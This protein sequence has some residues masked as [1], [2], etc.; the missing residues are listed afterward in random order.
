MNRSAAL[1]AVALVLVSVGL[2]LSAGAVSGQSGAG[3]A[4][5]VGLEE[6]SPGGDHPTNA[7]PS[8]RAAGSYHEYAL[9]YLPTG[10]FVQEGEDS[11]S[12]R[13]MRPG[14]NVRRDKLQLWSKR[15][16]DADQKE[17]VIRIAY[18][19][20]GTRT[21]PNGTTRSVATN[22]T[23]T[24]KTATL[25]PGYDYVNLDVRSH[26][27]KK[28]TTMCVQ[29]ADDDENCLMNPTGLRWQFHH[30]TSKA[31]EAI[32]VNSR[33]GQL[34]WGYGLLVLPFFGFTAITL[35]T[36]REAVKRA[37]APPKISP[38]WWIVAAV[39]MA[40]TVV[41]GWTWISE[42]LVR[43]PWV[44][45]AAL[46]VLLGIMAVEWFSNR[47]FKSLFVRFSLTDGH[48]PP[49]EDMNEGENG[50]E[51]APGVLSAD[52]V[53]MHMVRSEDGKRSAIR[54]GLRKFVAR[55]RGATADFEPE[56]DMQTRVE[57]DVG[58]YE[59]LYLLHPED[60]EPLEYR[61]EHHELQVPELLEYEETEDGES[62]LVSV[63]AGTY[64]FGAG[65]LVVSYLAGGYLV[66]SEVLGLLVGA[67]VL[68]AWKLYRPVQGSLEANLAPIH[69][70][71]AVGTMLTHA[72]KL[73]QAKAWEELYR[74][75]TREKAQN[76]ADKKDLADQ[77][78]E[79][80][81]DQLFDRHTGESGGPVG[82]LSNGEAANGEEKAN[83]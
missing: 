20:E 5:K 25:G 57:C 60:E 28:R 62:E 3:A 81:L 38:I 26:Y 23:T 59:E 54:S 29:E 43:A 77:R 82:Q 74:D 24:T 11:P 1:V 47:T 36:G 33:G 75:L 31:Y 48:E 66:G 56:G 14:A 2:G 7:P 41:A 17:I 49:A 8:V 69:Y 13:Y 32:S 50:P 27:D 34:G 83:E 35:Y 30:H 73:G 68:T 40:I 16:Y 19:N 53:P 12:W 76:K 46:G 6:L 39:V 45:T 72:E 4:D 63:N 58:P 18:W 51:D 80:Q 9:K 79:S 61:P 71:R 44:V 52:V 37:K 42:T 64:L 21:G 70:H 55:A 15:A 22:V 65:A 67:G 78:S 10:L